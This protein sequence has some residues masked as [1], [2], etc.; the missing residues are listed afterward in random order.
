MARLAMAFDYKLCINCHA[1]EVACKEENGIEL[2]ASKH[3]LWIDE[4]NKPVGDFWNLDTKKSK[5]MQMQCQECE[6]APCLKA[7]PNDAIYKDK[8]HIIRL[9]ENKCDLSLDCVKACPYDARYVDTR[10]KITDKCIFC[11]DTRLAR[12]ESTTA[13]QITCPAKL[14]YFGDLDDPK[15]EISQILNIRDY[16][17][18][19]PEKGTKPKLY[20]LK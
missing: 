1:C 12:G 17:Q 14:R 10:K 20:Y 15:S 8:N 6:E 13:C 2:G 7:C 18:L 19:K 9:Y 11:A 16:F 4:Q 5:F 3:R